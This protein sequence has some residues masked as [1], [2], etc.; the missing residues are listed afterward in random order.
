MR[1][2]IGRAGLSAE[3]MAEQKVH[4][5]LTA[6]ERGGRAD[7]PRLAEALSGPGE[8]LDEVV[9]QRMEGLLGRDLGEARVHSGPQA[10]HLAD[11]LGA[12]AFTLGPRIFAP[13]RNLSPTTEQGAGLLA[14]ELTHVV[15][16]TQPQAIG[17]AAVP[18]A[19]EAPAAGPVPQLAAAGD[20][21]ATR[22]QAGEA[23]ALAAE[24]AARKGARS[25]EPE[26]QEV[27]VEA[28]ADRVYQLMKQDLRLE[29]ERGI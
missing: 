29:R 18:I 12:E 9:R 7:W 13:A 14:H 25:S 23:E 4:S 26:R 21:G 10:E 22:D 3:R 27:D 20:R 24:Q 2:G 1:R 8:R 19:G 15:Q 28:L 11:Y 16:Q 17:P 5:L 6:L